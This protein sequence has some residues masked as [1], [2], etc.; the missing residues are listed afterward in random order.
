MGETL[1]RPLLVEALCEFI[2]AANSSWDWTI[3][4]QLYARIGDEFSERV[5]LQGLHLEVQTSPASRPVAAVQSGPERLQ[6]KRA[7]GSAMVQV[8]EHLLAVNHLR[9]Y[10]RWEDFR[11]LIVRV[12]REYQAI[13]GV[14]DLHRIGLRYINQIELPLSGFNLQDFITLDPPLTGGLDRPLRGVYQR[15]ELDYSDPTG[16]LI[17]QT[18]IQTID[19]RRNLVLDL[20]FGSTQVEHLRGTDQ[21]EGWLDQ[22]HE[23]V[24]QA[25]RSS[26][27]ADF[28]ET[29]RRGNT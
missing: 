4:G 19:E 18:G 11:A 3:P 13:V 23:H 25:F 27:N 28:Y 5:Q 21:V 29:L 26:L 10:P 1:K 9:P 17:H 22:A 24:Y 15:Y 14:G 7:N 12:L 8:G 6:L 2:F 20:D 16:I